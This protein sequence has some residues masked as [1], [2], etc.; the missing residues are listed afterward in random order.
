MTGDFDRSPFY[1]GINLLDERRRQS[2]L[3]EHYVVSVSLGW[4]ASASS[5]MGTGCHAA[6][7]I[8]ES[9][10]VNIRLDWG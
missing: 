10:Y 2:Q 1:G 9:V 8:D 4:T 3:N 6:T 5:G 7:P